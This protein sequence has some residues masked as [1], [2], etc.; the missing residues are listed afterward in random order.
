[1]CQMVGDVHVEWLHIVSISVERAAI[2]YAGTVVTEIVGMCT[3][4]NA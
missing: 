4:L 3:N 1:M 2:P